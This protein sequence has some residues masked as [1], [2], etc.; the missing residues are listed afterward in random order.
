MGGFAWLCMSPVYL[1][2]DYCFVGRALTTVVS[3]IG[4]WRKGADVGVG[5]VLKLDD[6]LGDKAAAMIVALN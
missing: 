2:A 1:L 3:A 4:R 6:I 5:K